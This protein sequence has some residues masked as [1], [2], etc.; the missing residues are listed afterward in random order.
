MSTDRFT[1]KISKST[2]GCWQWTA[3]ID[4]AGYGRFGVAGSVVYAHRFS[5]ESFIG[6]IAAG[7]VIDHKCRN[8][9]CVNP[10]HLHAVTR[11]QNIEHLSGAPRSNKSSGIR[12]VSWSKSVGKWHVYLRHHGANVHGGYFDNLS[13]AERAAIALRNKYFTNNLADPRETA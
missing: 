12:G 4:K 10:D 6:P 7:M 1:S 5:Y 11:K 3:F 8:R 9:S 13:D 2:S